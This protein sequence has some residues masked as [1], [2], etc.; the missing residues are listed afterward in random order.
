[1]YKEWSAEKKLAE[2]FQS[3]LL[4]KCLRI[5]GWGKELISGLVWTLPSLTDI[6]GVEEKKNYGFNNFSCNLPFFF[7]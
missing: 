6:F 3:W 5:K 2:F 7:F 1:M 4:Q